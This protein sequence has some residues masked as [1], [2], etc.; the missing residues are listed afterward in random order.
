MPGD[1]VVASSLGAGRE[2]SLRVEK[3]DADVRYTLGICKLY[4]FRGSMWVGVRVVGDGV[5]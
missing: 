5:K 3:C 4:N 2:L 1:F